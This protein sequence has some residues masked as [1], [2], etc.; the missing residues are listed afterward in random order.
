MAT[1]TRILVVDDEENI[2]HML[3][4]MLRKE[5]Y[6]V[7][8][9]EDGAQALELLLNE[10]VDTVLCDIRMPNLDGLQLLHELQTRRVA[11][12]VIVMSAYAAVDDALNAIK[13]GAYDY[14]AKPFRKEEVLLTLRK[15]EERR[16]LRDAHEILRRE[17]RGGHSFASIIAR[18]PSMKRVFETIQ[19][20]A[21]HKS[22]VLISGESGTG[23]EMVARALHS[24][25]SRADGPYITVNCG[26][27][28]ENLLESELF[29]HIKG[30]FT[31]AGRDKTG[32][33]EEAHGG[34][35]FLDEI[36]DLP[37]SLQVKLLRV[38]Q[39]SEIRRVG[40]NKTRVIDVRVVAASLKAL[41]DLVKEGR[42]R[43]DLY[44]R[45][46][47]LPINLPPLRDRREDVPLLVEHFI[48][49]YNRIMGDRVRGV[50][51]QALDQLCRYDWPGNVRE[52]ENVIE[53]AMVL[54]ESDILGPESL[55]E[56]FGNAQR[57]SD[58]NF[59][60]EDLSI[61]KATRAIERSLI[62][63][64]LA[65]TGGNRTAASK[66]LEISHRALLYKL[67]DYFPDGVPG[68]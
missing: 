45:L 53:R 9:A 42:F 50:S 32:L 14:I 1:K 25:S 65:E 51:P 44:Y 31:D 36:G 66:L 37:L 67:K 28:P 4:I 29:G 5:G 21:D 68:E 2:R 13:A 22:T 12:T 46:N 35:L 17:A 26:A 15:A 52:L 59:E 16:R 64:A 41:G 40:D 24:E 55:P 7:Q 27:I 38:L 63:A 54:T 34:T 20:V 43:E 62:Q 23:K 60:F 6:L 48:A 3:S 47:V 57:T 8:L 56:Q 19:K 11:T 18:S 58:R 33:F 30:A 39:S 61:K 49:R 10:P